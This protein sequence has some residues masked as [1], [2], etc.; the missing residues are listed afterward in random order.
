M[1]DTN[2]E[3]VHAQIDQRL[4]ALASAEKQLKKPSSISFAERRDLT[5]KAA[6]AATDLRTLRAD[7]KDDATDPSEAVTTA[8]GAADLALGKIQDAWP[9]NKGGGGHVSQKVG[10]LRTGAA[11]GSQ[12]RPPDRVGE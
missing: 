2:P 8:L 9:A 11:A 5:N 12:T 7:V 1:S 4:A 3:T 6:R 10:H